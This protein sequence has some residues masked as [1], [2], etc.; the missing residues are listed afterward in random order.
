VWGKWGNCHF[1]QR[2]SENAENIETLHKNRSHTVHCP[3]SVSYK[4]MKMEIKIKIE[5]T[6]AA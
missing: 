2:Q 3:A 6:W 4:K 1:R 5:Y